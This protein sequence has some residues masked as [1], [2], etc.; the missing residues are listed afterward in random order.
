MV[1][2]LLSVAHLVFISPNK[3]LRSPFEEKQRGQGRG[4]S[5]QMRNKVI[6]RSNDQAKTQNLVLEE[7]KEELRH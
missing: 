2:V 1:R 5:V 7:G 6:Y 4:Q 3:D